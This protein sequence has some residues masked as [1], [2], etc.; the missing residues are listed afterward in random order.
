MTCYCQLSFWLNGKL[1][2]WMSKSTAKIVPKKMFAGTIKKDEGLMVKR[3]FSYHYR[4]WIVFLPPK[5][6]LAHI[7]RETNSIRYR[8][9]IDFWGWHSDAFVACGQRKLNLMNSSSSPKTFKDVQIKKPNSDLC[10]DVK[11][12]NMPWSSE[13]SKK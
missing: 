8:H 5:K 4:N 13:N 6:N 3:K 7:R 1:I 12:E 11:M 10:F 9:K 2:L